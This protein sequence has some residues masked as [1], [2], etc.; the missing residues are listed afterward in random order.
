MID[1]KEFLKNIVILCMKICERNG[2]CWNVC[3]VGLW[4]L[5]GRVGFKGDKG[6]WGRVG[7]RGL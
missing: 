2:K 6:N 3:L 1:M 4:G 7:K 5:L